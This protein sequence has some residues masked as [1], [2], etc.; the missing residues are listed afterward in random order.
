[1][2]RLLTGAAIVVMIAASVF[3]YFI[4]SSPCLILKDGDTGKTL[5]VYGIKE[6]NEFSITFVHSVNK[7]PVTDV[8]EIRG[9]VIYVVRTI[10]YSFGAGVQTEIE[11]G[12]TLEYGEDGSM[13][14]SGFDRPMDN[15]SYIVGT[16]SDHILEINGNS[17]KLR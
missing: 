13:I 9:G 2:K 1:M 17:V 3:I 7:S 6:G 10:Y 8:Y 4:L 11:E 16:V 12:Q 5:A 14:I 15:L